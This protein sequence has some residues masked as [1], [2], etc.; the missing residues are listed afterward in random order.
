MKKNTAARYFLKK[1][2]LTFFE[3]TIP[4]VDFCRVHPGY[5]VALP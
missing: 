5:I 1:R 2:T 4:A 3:G